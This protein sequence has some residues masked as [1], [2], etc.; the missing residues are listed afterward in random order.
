MGR[1]RSAALEGLVI[2]L[3]CTGRGSC[4]KFRS[5]SSR[6]LTCNPMHATC[7]TQDDDDDVSLPIASCYRSYMQPRAF[8]TSVSCCTKRRSHLQGRVQSHT[9]PTINCTFGEVRFNRISRASKS[10]TYIC[11]HTTKS[12]GPSEW[13]HSE[14][15]KD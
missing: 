11:R 10:P 15:D 2:G 7:R 14:T 3:E 1:P 8:A 5:I 12:T 4:S 6:Q 9:R 13:G